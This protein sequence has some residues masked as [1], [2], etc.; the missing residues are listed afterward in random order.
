MPKNINIDMKE[1]KGCSFNF[2]MIYR[3]ERSLVFNWYDVL[4]D[5]IKHYKEKLYVE[6][7]KYPQK[8]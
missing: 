5:E 2:N 3:Q 1:Y 4:E 8:T 6:R 7:H